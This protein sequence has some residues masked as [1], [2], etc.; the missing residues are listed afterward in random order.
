MQ[1]V[2]SRHIPVLADEAVDWLS[3]KPG[4]VYVDCT[5]GLGG[6]AALVLARLGGHGRL[7][8]IDRDQEAL[9][10]AQQRLAAYRELVTFHHEN[11]RNLPLLLHRLDL[12]QVDGILM[13]LGASRLQLTEPERGFSFREEGPLDMRMDRS[14]ATTAADL[15]HQL[16]VDEL[17]DLFRT[18]GEEPEARRIAAA[19]VDARR[20]QRIRTTQ[21]LAQLIQS[22]KRR[23][24]QHHPATQVFQALRI[25]VNQELEGL[26]RYLDQIINFLAPGGRLVVISFHSLEDRIVK[27]SFQLAAGKCICFRPGDL[28]RCP[29]VQRVNIL[30]RKPVLPAAE[31]VQ[32]NPSARSAKLR[33]VERV[34][35]PEGESHDGSK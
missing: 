35:F 9:E 25:A 16:S 19:I 21:Q 6:H 23:R 31:E 8:A 5:T 10:E 28:C 29:R 34:P 7:I 2:D 32:S 13:D 15:I 27:R 12:P 17:T 22:T 20:R 1:T 4:G 33:A 3:V 24:T 18:Y 14:Q 26:D 11:F 30:T